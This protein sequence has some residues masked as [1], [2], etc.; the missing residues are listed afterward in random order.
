LNQGAEFARR[1]P[2]HGWL[3]V[4]SI[5]DNDYDGCA[6]GD[7]NNNDMVHIHDSEWDCNKK[8]ERGEEVHG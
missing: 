8:Y 2:R 7:N 5:G 4:L 3:V 1:I 6:K